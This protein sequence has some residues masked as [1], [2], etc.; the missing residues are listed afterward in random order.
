[1]MQCNMFFIEFSGTPTLNS[2]GA[3]TILVLP[4]ISDN[5]LAGTYTLHVSTPF[6]GTSRLWDV[7]NWGNSDFIF[8]G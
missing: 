2:D 6:P 4:P 7:V 5:A 1:M 8:V 3:Y